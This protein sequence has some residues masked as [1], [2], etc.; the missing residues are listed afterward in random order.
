MV[1]EL[2]RLYPSLDPAVAEAMRLVPRHHFAPGEAKSVAYMQ[3][4]LPIGEGQVMSSPEA[5]AICL[6]ALDLQ[7]TDSVLEVGTGTGYLAACLSL[8]CKRVETWEARPKLASL[9]AKNLARFGATNVVLG[10]GPYLQEFGVTYDKVVYSCA[11]MTPKFPGRPRLVM[12][13]AQHQMTYGGCVADLELWVP[14]GLF[15]RREVLGSC[16]ACPDVALASGSV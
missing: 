14:D 4:P 10:V 8:L 6:D 5:C 12:P 13:R 16:R 1:A 11:T 2:I 7:P 9:A 15:Y 3:T